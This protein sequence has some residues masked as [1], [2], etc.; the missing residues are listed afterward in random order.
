M[1]YDLPPNIQL[2]RTLLSYLNA[3]EEWTA[4]PQQLVLT[5]R[6][7]HLPS[8]LPLFLSLLPCPRS[9]SLSD[10]SPTAPPHPTAPHPLLSAQ[11]NQGNTALHYASAYGQLKS[12]RA[13][14]A[15][16]AQPGR[17]N[18]WSWMPVSYS[19]TVQ[20]EVYFKGL[21]GE[22]GKRREGEGRA[23]VE[24]RREGGRRGGL[25]MVVGG[26]GEGRERAGSLE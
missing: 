5:A 14:L 6:T 1:L 16:G 9:S 18:A 23:S 13:L 22:A 25:R 21:L 19:L 24:E 10:P 17:R 15:A 7:P 2:H 12:V 26:E 11:D 4:D 20:A 8:L 3:K